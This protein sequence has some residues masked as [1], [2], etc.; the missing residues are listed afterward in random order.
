MNTSALGSE[1]CAIERIGHIQK[2]I[3]VLWGSP[4]LDA[5]INKL[6]MD[7][8]DGQRQ[9]FPVQVTQELL[10]LAEFNKFIQAIDLARKLK[11]SLRDALQKLDQVD[12]NS[13]NPLAGGGGRTDRGSAQVA[14]PAS[15]ART[16]KESGNAASSFGQMIF[17]LLTSKAVIFLIFLAITYKLISPYLFKTPV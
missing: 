7:S 10:Y 9:G 16:K 12:I 15:V 2:K 1:A 5:Y 8:R 4:E 3:C 14:R 6:L 13:E 17:T 11:I